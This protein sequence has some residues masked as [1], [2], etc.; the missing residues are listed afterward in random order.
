MTLD[1]KELERIHEKHGFQAYQHELS[2]PWPTMD[3]DMELALTIMMNYQKTSQ[4]GLRMLEDVE[5]DG[6]NYSIKLPDWIVAISSRLEKSYG[7]TTG[8]VIFE[9]VMFQ[10]SKK[11][12]QASRKQ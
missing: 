11:I 9:K 1:R 12:M 6:D 5:T 7:D 3:S 2:Q 4:D 10:I 8:G